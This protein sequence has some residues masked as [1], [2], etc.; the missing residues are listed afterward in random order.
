M[1][2]DTGDDELIISMERF[3]DDLK[4]VDCSE[5]MTM[6]FKSNEAYQDA[7][8]DWEWVNFNEKRTFILIANYPGCGRNRSRQPWVVSNV[9]Y[10]VPNFIVHLNAT[11]KNWTDIAHLYS[12]DFGIYQPLPSPNNPR[13]LIEATKSFSVDLYHALPSTIFSSSFGQFSFGIE[14]NECGTS[15][16]LEI[17]GHV[18]SNLFGLSQF[19]VSVIP[20]GI[21]AHLALRMI[22]SGELPVGGWEKDFDILSVGIPGFSI[23]NILEV[24]PN[25]QIDGGFSL[26]TLEGAV[27]ITSGITA[28]IPDSSLA[29]VDF[30]SKKKLD[31]H[32][33]KP[34]FSTTPFQFNA[35]VDADFEFFVQL[36][37]AVSLTCLGG[38]LVLISYVLH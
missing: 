27:S 9:Q 13:A 6:A 24:G 18:E 8:D 25:L 3:A 21:Q 15:G 20:H 5:Q 29:E 14:C 32:G 22:A 34:T 33:W 10:D 28:T 35:K 17:S 12:L 19:K 30:A 16:S 36:S 11:K 31:I 38:S 7:I 1:T 23:P 26:S 4:S 2:L 37:V